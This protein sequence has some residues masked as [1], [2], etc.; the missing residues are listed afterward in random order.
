MKTVTF[1]ATT[2]Q[3]PNQKDFRNDPVTCSGEV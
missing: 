3:F 1:M 2:Y